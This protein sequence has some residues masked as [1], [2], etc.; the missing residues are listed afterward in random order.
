MLSLISKYKKYFLFFI[1]FV[2]ILYGNSLKNKYALDDD[3]ITVTNFPVTGQ[4]Y[5]PN[6]ELVAKGFSGIGKIWKTRYARDA[7][8]SFDFRPVTTTSF[9]IEYGI[10]GQNPFVSHFINVL[11]YAITICVL[12]CVL[13]KL[14]SSFE[15]GETVALTASFVFLILPIHTEVVNNI[16]C[17]DEIFA[18]LFPL[19]SLYYCIKFY[20]KNR[21]KLKISSRLHNFGNILYID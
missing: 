5:I 20:D 19:L 10:F 9:A 4:N 8:S 7:E 15:N 14:F 2:F 1:S 17:R 11:L 12:Y 21:I 6:N 16:K 3:Y 18:F 13:L